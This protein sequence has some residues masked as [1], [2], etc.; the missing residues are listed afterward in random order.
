MIDDLFPS[1][2]NRTAG[3][4]FAPFKGCNNFPVMAIGK[5]NRDELPGVPSLSLCT[6]EIKN[7]NEEIYCNG[8]STKPSSIRSGSS[9]ATNGQPNFKAEQ[10]QTGRKQRRCWSPELHRRFVSALQQLGGAQGLNS[11]N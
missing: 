9:S 8:F 4:A 11:R 7:S 3:R 6:P 1:G 2:K 10:Q 5:D